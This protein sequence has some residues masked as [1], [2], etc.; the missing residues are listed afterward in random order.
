M[1]L[2]ISYSE[3]QELIASRYNANVTLAKVSKKEL[4][5]TVARKVIIKTV[6]INI[7]L[8]IEEFGNQSVL[9]MYDSGF[10]I[11]LVI[12]GLLIFVEK[13]LPEYGRMI[14]KEEGNRIR[15]NPEKV[16]KF[17]TAIKTIDLKGIDFEETGMNVHFSLK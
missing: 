2:I 8:T 14:S 17:A 10:G 11:D 7:N 1:K 5:V 13:K 6:Q 4:R 16:E 9:I 12:C 3:L 15:L